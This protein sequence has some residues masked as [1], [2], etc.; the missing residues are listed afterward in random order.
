MKWSKVKS[1][2]V[3]GNYVKWIDVSDVMPNKMKWS[4]VKQKTE[5]KWRKTKVKWSK[6]KSSQVKW[7]YLKWSDVSEVK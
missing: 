6:M 1:N 2:K 3:K 5:A 4:S 7:K